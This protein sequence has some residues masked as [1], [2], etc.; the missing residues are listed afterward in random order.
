MIVGKNHDMNTGTIPL[1][2]LDQETGLKE[3]VHA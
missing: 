2:V 3:E 1:A